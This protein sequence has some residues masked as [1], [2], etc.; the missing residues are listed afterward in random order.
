M[1][2]ASEPGEVPATLSLLIATVISYLLSG[3]RLERHGLD[4]GGTSV[5][6]RSPP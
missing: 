3:L 4:P 5:S 1:V 6:F 2:P